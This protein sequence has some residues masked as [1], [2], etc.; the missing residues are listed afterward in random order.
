MT[1][2]EKIKQEI[3]KRIESMNSCPFRN[4][5]LGSEKF[6]EGEL[7]AYKQILQFIDSL[8]EE[9][10]SENLEGRK[11]NYNER[12]KRFAQTEQFKKSY[13]D[14]SLG[15]E[16]PVREDLEEY[17]KKLAKGAALDK[18]NLIWMCKKGAEWQK[19]KDEELFSEDIWNYIEEN[20][21]NITEEEKLRLYDVSIKS[22]L[23]GA[24]TFK[25]HIREEMMKNAVECVVED[26]CGD[27]P[28]ITIPLNPQDF[29][30][31][32]KVKIIIVKTE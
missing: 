30:T 13:C 32:D 22:R 5:E 29:K 19:Q 6:S 14:K 12:Y 17:A 9:P 27:S 23:A 18:H 7:Y 15:K 3:E 11:E 25:N 10:A 31:N 28:E 26:W 1:D 20:Y 16:E 2:K 8:P 21:P 24:D 4:A